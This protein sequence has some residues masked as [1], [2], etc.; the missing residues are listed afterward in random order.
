M[1]NNSLNKRIAFASEN[2]QAKYQIRQ[3]MT[4]E[5]RQRERI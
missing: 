2:F 3:E 5:H 1:N 4:N